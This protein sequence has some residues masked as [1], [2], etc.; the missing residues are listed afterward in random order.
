MDCGCGRSQ[1]G[2]CIGC[3]KLSEEEYQEALKKYKAKETD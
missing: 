1:T 2:K 3:H